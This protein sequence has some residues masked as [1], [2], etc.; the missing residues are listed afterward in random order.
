MTVS[1]GGDGLT[2]DGLNC[3]AVSREQVLRT[4]EGGVSA[5]NL[6]SMS[7]FIGL[8]ESLVELEQNRA[9]IEAMSDIATVV[10]SVAEIEAAHGVPKGLLS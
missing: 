9:R 8:A 2:I 7:P 4:L 5:I 1:A 10:T 3:A 6:T